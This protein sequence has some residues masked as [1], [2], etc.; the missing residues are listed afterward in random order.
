MIP[1][2]LQLT[3]IL[4][5]ETNHSGAIGGGIGAALIIVLVAVAVFIFY[6]YYCKM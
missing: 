2:L 3:E 5:E 1:Q 4:V 6:R